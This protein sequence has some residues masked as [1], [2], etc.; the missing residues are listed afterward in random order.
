LSLAGSFKLSQGELELRGEIFTLEHL[1]EL[2][3]LERA[4]FPAPWSE[5]LLAREANSQA[6]AWNMVVK[7]DGR[8][9]A[10]FFNWIVLD[11]MHLLN[12]A[13]HPDLQGLGLGGV[14]LDWLV[15]EA[16]GNGYNNINLEVR[17]S[18]LAARGLYESRG[19]VTIYRRRGYYTDNGEDALV[20]VKFIGPETELLEI[21]EDRELS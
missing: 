1:Q 11:E 12:F 21:E 19:F 10:F 4:C 14:I 7:V 9:R 20:M 18:N 13:I 8:V 15:I 3:L 2:L 5:A 6:H 16:E 17:E